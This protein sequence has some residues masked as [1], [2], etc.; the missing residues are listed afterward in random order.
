MV[1]T[2]WGQWQED[3]DADRGRQ[4]IYITRPNLPDM[5]TGDRL[6]LFL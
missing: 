5:E 4:P 3:H 1:G 6:Y 2:R